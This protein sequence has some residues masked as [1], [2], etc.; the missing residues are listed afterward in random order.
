MV[1]LFEEAFSDVLGFRGCTSFKDKAKHLIVGCY[2]ME[3]TVLRIVCL[4]YIFRDFWV[5]QWFLAFG[6][7]LLE[8]G[9][10]T[11]LLRDAYVK[12]VLCTVSLEPWTTLVR[13]AMFTSLCVTKKRPT[14]SRCM[15]SQ[16]LTEPDGMVK[17]HWK[18]SPVSDDPKQAVVRVVG[19]VTQ[20]E[21]EMRNMLIWVTCFSSRSSA[22]ELGHP[23]LQSKKDMGDVVS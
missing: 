18:A 16:V 1:M 15:S 22:S 20:S 6:H 5:R 23:V 8:D 12:K 4:F 2:V 13:S 21:R 19:Q 7:E 17:Y 9:I 10:C 14:K 3:V 11:C